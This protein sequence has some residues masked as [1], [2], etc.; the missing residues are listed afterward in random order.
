MSSRAFL[1][2]ALCSAALVIPSC[3]GIGVVWAFAFA[4][5]CA[6][7]HRLALSSYPSLRFQLS[8]V[9]ALLKSCTS[10]QDTMFTLEGV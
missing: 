4:F 9:D 3:E 5:A 6:I 7:R 10:D 1:R 2:R 8:P